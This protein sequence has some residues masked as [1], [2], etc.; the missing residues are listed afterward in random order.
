[1]INTGPSPSTRLGSGT[2]EVT[3]L[4]LGCASLAGQYTAVSEEDAQAT[5]QRAWA[6]GIRYFDT[7]PVYGA[8]LSEERLGRALQTLP[9]DELSLST[10]VGYLLTPLEKGEAGWSMF[11]ESTRRF[12][13]DFSRDGVLR[14]LEASLTRLGTDR[15]DSVWIHDP[16]EGVGGRDGLP[17]DSR[18][19][20]AEVMAEAYPALD[21]LR[22]TGVIGAIGVGINQWQMLVDFVTAG[23]FDA[24]LLAGRYSLLDHADALQHLF[25]LCAARNTSIVVG[26]PYASGILASGPVPGATFEYAAADDTV[27]DRVRHLHALCAAHGVPLPA[28]ALQFSTAHPIV[29]S[30]I[31]GCRTAQ[32]VDDALAW[33]QFPIPEALWEDLRMAGLIHDQSP[34]PSPL[35]TGH[36]S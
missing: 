24:F 27:L 19:H 29:A 32:E 35:T 12:H 36:H 20:F 34:T 5:V 8:G 4:G 18:S 11:P 30:V 31:P 6:G 13:F 21:E 2:V 15:I 17:A 1:V 22:S 33:S 26:G 16:D 14:S 23:D 28:A 3:R 7:A 25:P 10:K 9:R